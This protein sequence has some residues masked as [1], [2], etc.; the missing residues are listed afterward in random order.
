[1]DL[2]VAVRRSDGRYTMIVRPSCVIQITP[3]NSER[4][5]VLLN[6]GEVS[7]LG[8]DLALRTHGPGVLKVFIVAGRSDA[9]AEQLKVW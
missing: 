2:H 3:L 8:S 6:I 1:M 7:R 5:F 4:A 9:C